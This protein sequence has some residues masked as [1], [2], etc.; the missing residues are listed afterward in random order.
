MDSGRAQTGHAFFQ[1]KAT[2]GAYLSALAHLFGPDHKHVGHRAVADPHFAATELVAAG[3]FVGAGGHAAG[4]RAVVGFGQAK[5]ANELARGQLGQVFLALRLGAKFKNRHHHQG[6]LH[7]HH[8]AVA[9][10]Y[11][12]HFAGD[13][14]V[15]H[16]VQAGATVLLGDRGAKQAEFAHFSKNRYVGGAISK[17]LGHTRQQFVLAVGRSRI[18]HHALVVAQLAVQQKGVLPVECGVGHGFLR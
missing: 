14:A 3:H 13:Q 6:R 10:V 12:L 8:A 4:V 9:A 15:G 18:A 16:V 2:N 7:A 5:A 17:G 1:H 11:A